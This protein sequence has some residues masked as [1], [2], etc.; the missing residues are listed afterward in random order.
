M[1]E[2]LRECQKSGSISRPGSPNKRQRVSTTESD[3]TPSQWTE[4]ISW[5]SSQVTTVADRTQSASSVSRTPSPTKSIRSRRILLDYTKPSVYFG[6]PMSPDGSESDSDSSENGLDTDIQAEIGRLSHLEDSPDVH[7][8]PHISAITRRFSEEAAAPCLPDEIVKQLRKLSPVE[9]FANIRTSQNPRLSLEPSELLRHVS[10][11]FRIAGQLYATSLDESAW[12]PLVREVLIGPDSSENTNAFIK[13]E[14]AHLRVLCSELL[15]THNAKPIS[16]V[17]VDH[18]LQFNPANR[19]VNKLYRSLFTS[20]PPSFSL[21][22]FND[23][24]AEKTFTCA[25]VEVKAPGGNFQEATYQVAVASA[26]I[27]ERLRLLDRQVGECSRD[28][29]LDMPVLGWI[30]HGHFWY[31]NVS[32]KQTE[33]SIVSR[34]PPNDRGTPSNYD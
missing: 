14:E 9:D 16:S 25:I 18:V 2:N 32:Y 11:L 24:V 17:K 15:P 13:Q 1:S 20:Q 30:V 22:A 3:V 23:P 4:R 19:R 26:V 28:G 29:D 27:L 33:D 6:P 21:S 7:I 34:I 31:L 8:P 5:M 10:S 12:Y